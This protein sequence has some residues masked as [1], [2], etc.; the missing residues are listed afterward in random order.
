MLPV[1]TL[2]AWAPLQLP[3]AS[4]A[5]AG[6]MTAWLL[7]Q[8][9]WIMQTAWSTGLCNAQASYTGAA[10]Q[11]PALPAPHSAVIKCMFSGVTY[12]RQDAV[13][14]A[15]KCHHDRGVCES[16]LVGCLNQLLHHAAVNA[17]RDCTPGLIAGVCA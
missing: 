11:Q 14:I 5:A 12:P 15:S 10:G 2:Q 4:S 3:C 1:G 17:A 13:A 8:G 7:K 9:L 16:W 6:V